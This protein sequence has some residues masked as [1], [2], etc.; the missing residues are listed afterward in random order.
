MVSGDGVHLKPIAWLRSGTSSENDKFYER[1]EFFWVTPLWKSVPLVGSHEPIK[2]RR[3]MPLLH[4]FG[5]SPRVRGRGRNE[6]EV[7]DR[8][9]GIIR[10]GE[11]AHRES[12]VGRC[13]L[14]AEFVRGLSARQKNNL[15]EPQFCYG[16]FSDVGV[17]EVD[18]VKSATKKAYFCW[19][20]FLL[21]HDVNAKG[22]GVLVF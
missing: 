3:G 17:S 20:C 11:P 19:G 18:G 13:V 2:L 21:G 10:S 16:L 7:I 5:G 1:C 8:C 9:P 22:Y 12:V 15:V 6:V 14:L 4:F